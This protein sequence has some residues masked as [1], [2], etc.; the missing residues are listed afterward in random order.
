MQYVFTNY[1]QDISNKLQNK[2][3]VNLVEP[4]HAPEVIARHIIL[5]RMI[6]TGQSK[7]HNERDTQK[8]VMEASVTAGIDD[9][10]PTKLAILENMIA[11]GEYEANVDVTIVMTD[12]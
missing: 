5:E 12:S 1:E 4:F 11:Q 6:R 7:I 10:A 3:T 2:L 8:I 9:A